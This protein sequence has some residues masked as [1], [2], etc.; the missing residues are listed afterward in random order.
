VLLLYA[1]T[2]RYPFIGLDDTLLIVE[3]QPFLRDLANLPHVFAQHAWQVA[4]RQSTGAY[5]RPLMIAS[6]MWDTQLAGASPWAYHLTN[7]LLHA[8]ACCLLLRL[9]GLLGTPRPAAMLLAGLFALHPVAVMVV[10][11]VP[12]RN[13][14]LLAC[15]VLIALITLAG[16]VR[17]GHRPSLAWHLLAVVLALFT[18]E[19]GV[20]LPFLCLT[21][22]ALVAKQRVLSRTSVPLLVGWAASLLLW[23]A[24]RGSVVTS[25]PVH[26]SLPVLA[27]HFARHL[28]VVL[29]YVGKAVF[30]VHLSAMPTIADTPW[31]YGAVA[32][33]LIVGL[34]ALTPQRDQGRL[35]FG[36]IWFLAFVLP[37]LV[38]PVLVGQEPRLYVPL[39]GLLVVVAE[40][41]VIRAFPARRTS[42]G[43][44]ALVACAFAGLTALRLGNFKDRAAFWEGAVRTSP[45][46]SLAHLNLGAVH[47]D[48][49]RL[50]TAE[51]E[52]QHALELNPAEPMA[53]NNLGVIA[54]RRN[55]TLEA[56]GH[57]EREIA[58]NPGYADAYFN[59]GVS[60][61]QA[62]EGGKAAQQWEKALTLSPYHVNALRF[63]SQ[64]WQRLDPAKAA[65]YATRLA[66]VTSP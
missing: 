47:L 20:A 21:Y 11:W 10:A 6:F 28:V 64:Y 27:G 41:R 32:L 39:M 46:S 7:I 30:P 45:H 38:V 26:R 56:R 14:S 57:F 31:I 50:E 42:V 4:H 25:D 54:G 51:A 33:V 62:G 37:T 2:L 23:L 18:K 52:F 65:L 13:D 12:G 43:L 15:F 53:N 5:Y 24:V 60:Y 9:L 49:G 59:L 58:V 8:L 61:L 66:A 44:A 16:Y 35:A 29:H 48:A 3:N 1:P 17:T 34:L 55:R 19:P 40:T 63:L 36:T 22:L